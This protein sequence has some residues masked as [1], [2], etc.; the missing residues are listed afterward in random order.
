MRVNHTRLLLTVLF[1]ALAPTALA[2]T[3][4]RG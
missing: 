3:Q 4:V 2:S 1:L